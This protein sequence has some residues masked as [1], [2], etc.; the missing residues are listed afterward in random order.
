MCL[1]TYLRWKLWKPWFISGKK[2]QGQQCPALNSPS[3]SSLPS[4]FPAGN[5]QALPVC[6]PGLHLCSCQCCG[7][8]KVSGVGQSHE[9]EEGQAGT[10]PGKSPHPQGFG[11]ILKVLKEIIQPEQP[12]GFK[13]WSRDVSRGW[14]WVLGKG[15]YPKGWSRVRGSCWG[16]RALGGPNVLS[17]P[18]NNSEFPWTQE[19][20]KPSYFHLF[21]PSLFCKIFILFYISLCFL[22]V[23][24]SDVFSL[25]SFQLSC[26]LRMV[27]LHG[28][29][30]DLDSYPKELLLFLRW[31]CCGF[32]DAAL[33]LH[34]ENKD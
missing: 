19:K 23:P 13:G 17:V 3:W 31:L 6:P 33:V 22:V 28:I 10:G 27:T 4:D 26:L 14:G 18:S 2:Q 15:F 24:P 5:S 7:S 1:L 32:C 11:V 9:E 20:S 12:L 29:P 25:V 16:V 21:F 8:R 34:G 30:E